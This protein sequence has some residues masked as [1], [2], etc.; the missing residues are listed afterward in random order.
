LNLVDPAFGLDVEE[1]LAEQIAWF[2]TGAAPTENT[3]LS[4][5]N[6][7]A[8]RGNTVTITLKNYKWSNGQPVTAQNVMFWLNMLSAVGSLDWGAYTGFP[9]SVVSNIK[10]VSP[11][12][13]TMT[14]DKSYDTAAALQETP[15]DEM[16][17]EP[18]AGADRDDPDHLYGSPECAKADPETSHFA[19]GEPQDAG[20][21]SVMPLG[22]APRWQADYGYLQLYSPQ[23][24]AEAT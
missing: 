10:V 20:R 6:P 9:N 1:A 18:R 17:A 3:S 2:G 8:F 24:Q 4:L 11:T 13:L 19:P 22:H 23:H 16:P 15:L 21:W 14:M 7:P 12:E 5:A